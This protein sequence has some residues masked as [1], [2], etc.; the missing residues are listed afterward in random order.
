MGKSLT[1]YSSNLCAA[2]CF[3]HYTSID[4]DHGSSVPLICDD[5]RAGL[6]KGHVATTLVQYPHVFQG[7][8]GGGGGLESVRIVE[9]LRTVEERTAALNGVFG[10][11]RD[12]GTYP[13]LRGW[14]NEVTIM[15]MSV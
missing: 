7:V 2:L 3:M 9:G 13:C 5:V 1:K 10:D 11:L 4:A 8:Y 12:K 15:S 6:I 14:R